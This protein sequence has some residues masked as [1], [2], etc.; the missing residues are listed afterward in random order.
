MNF[1]WMG[2][3]LSLG[4]ASSPDGRVKVRPWQAGEFGGKSFLANA[5]SF[6]SGRI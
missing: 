6:R 1:L 5:S 2:R 4:S 3:P